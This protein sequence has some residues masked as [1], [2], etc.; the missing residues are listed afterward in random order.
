MSM[1]LESDLVTGH[2]QELPP[3]IFGWFHFVIYDDGADRM[4][5]VHTI[6]RP[7]RTSVAVKD[8]D[9][10]WGAWHYPAP[11]T[12]PEL[13]QSSPNTNP[14]LHGGLLYVLFNDGKLAVY[15][16]VKHQEDHG[17]LEFLDKPGSFGLD[18]EDAYLFESD[19]GELMAVLAAGRHGTPVHV[20]KLDEKEM[21]WEE[22]ES[23]NGRAVFTGTLTTLMRKADVEWMQNKVFFPRLHDWP[24]TVHVDIVDRDGEVAFVP[25]TSTGA[26]TAAAKDGGN[27]WAYEL[28]SA[29]SR[30]FW[31]TEKL[32]YSIWV[33]FK[34][35]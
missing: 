27:L 28:G 9:G 8:E 21:E 25:T 7:P 35:C 19:E 4:F 30:E 15:D 22:V 12:D 24:E 18:C 33:D 17:H 11:F 23:L 16:R 26:D 20:V 14:V 6:G 1:V 5:G 13:I 31:E 2:V 29:E 3:I 32:D 10:E 34:T